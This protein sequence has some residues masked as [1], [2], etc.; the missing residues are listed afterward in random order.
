MAATIRSIKAAGYAALMLLSVWGNGAQATDHIDGYRAISTPRIDLTDLYA[1]TRADDPQTLV[2]VLNTMTAPLP[3]SRP[4]RDAVFE[5][6]MAPIG[7]DDAAQRYVLGCRWTA[8]GAQ[9]SDSAGASLTIAQG[10]Q[11]STDG[12]TIFAGKRS[13]P[14]V[15]NGI[16][17]TQL[18]LQ[19]SVPAPSSANIIA[20][21]NVFAL[22][23][24]LDLGHAMPA[25]GGRTLAIG[26]QVRD[27]ASG[28]I[29]DR[30]GRP[31][32]ANIAL[33]SNSGADLRDLLNGQPALD[34]PS[35]IAA[36][37]R[38]RLRENL[39]RYDAMDPAPYRTDKDRLA[40]ILA[41][42]Y[43]TIDPA[44]PCTNS[45]YFALEWADLSGQ[46]ARVCG[47]R[48]LGEDVIDRVYGLLI[49]GDG[50]AQ[51]ADGA[52]LPTQPA[53]DEFPYLAPPNQ[54]GTA[55][56]YAVIGRALAILSVAGPQR[57]MLIGALLVGV[58]L[59]IW[60]LWRLLRRL[61]RAK[62]G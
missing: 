33:Q 36:Q 45:H 27:V 15:L 11:A 30:V 10:G 24:Q 8:Q 58:L 39:D 42:D 50:A 48:P 38:Q 6:V 53:G 32:I 23:A 52:S 22:V 54:G 60:G 9:C 47:G 55:L 62:A 7:G 35:D 5:I 29:L 19:D 26:A 13:D 12:V 57:N 17:A 41:Q 21:L 61:L 20:H 46:A 3:W 49:M 31:E 56:L 59:L 43:L 28:Q 1:F 14:F 51:I 4:D 18:A 37:L 16:W 25:L 40:Q 44:L 34:L 2:V